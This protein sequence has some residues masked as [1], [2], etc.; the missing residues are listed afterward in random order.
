[1][2]WS[3][4][5]LLKI[6][7]TYIHTFNCC[8]LAQKFPLD[9]QTNQFWGIFPMD[10][11]LIISLNFPLLVLCISAI[12]CLAFRLGPVNKPNI[13]YRFEKILKHRFRI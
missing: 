11:A 6:E 12:L 3:C 10:A 8:Y 1:M 13:F 5:L 4:G 2:Y 7:I 9:Y